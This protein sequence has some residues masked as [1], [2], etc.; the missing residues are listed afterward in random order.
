MGYLTTPFKITKIK[1]IIKYINLGIV[2][3]KI[4]TMKIFNQANGISFLVTLSAVM[5]GLAVHQAYIAK[6]INKKG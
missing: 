6:M 2:N 1:L 5:V 4:R 3:I